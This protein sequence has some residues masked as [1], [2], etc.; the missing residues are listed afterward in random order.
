M[1]SIKILLFAIALMIFV[2]ALHLFLVDFLIT[3]LLILFAL[4]FI[5][6]GL[7]SND[8]DSTK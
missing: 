3:D 8:E 6:I 5:I 1:R 4:P 7:I 2:I